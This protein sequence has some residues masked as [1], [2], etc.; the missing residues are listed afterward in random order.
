MKPQFTLARLLRSTAFF[1]V[2]VWAVTWFWLYPHMIREALVLIPAAFGGAIGALFGK[3]PLG[4]FWGF[5][6]TFIL[7]GTGLL[8]AVLLD[9]AHRA[10]P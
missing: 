4:A 7:L 1:A 2:G 10:F 5:A 3:T 8:L 6:A 9:V